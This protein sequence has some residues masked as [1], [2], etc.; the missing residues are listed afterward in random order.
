MAWRHGH[1][2]REFP[3]QG[4][5][6]EKRTHVVTTGSGWIVFDCGF[7]VFHVAAGGTKR[8]TIHRISGSNECHRGPCPN[9]IRAIALD[10]SI[11][12]WFQLF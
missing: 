6:N 11:F 1:G 9:N 2:T 3:C 4:T 7:A 10:S 5:G 12:T 8:E